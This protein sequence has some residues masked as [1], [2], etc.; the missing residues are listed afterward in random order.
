MNVP[1]TPIDVINNE[2]E[3][4]D[5]DFEESE[6]L[7]ASH[8]EADPDEIDPEMITCP[9]CETV[10]HLSEGA[11]SNPNC[12]HVFKLSSTGHLLDGFVCDEGQIEYVESGDETEMEFSGEDT[13]YESESENSDDDLACWVNEDDDDSDWKP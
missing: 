9:L 8:M 11:C 2:M 7:E 5:D 4:F 10:T 3:D 12:N 13:D 1:D 6:T